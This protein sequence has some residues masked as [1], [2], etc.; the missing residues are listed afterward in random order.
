MLGDPGRV[1][2]GDGRVG[3]DVKVAK[4]LDTLSGRLRVPVDDPGA[5]APPDP[6]RG[7]PAGPQAG[8]T[9]RPPPASPATGGGP[10]A[11]VGR[12]HG[13][14]G[15][16]PRSDLETSTATDRELIADRPERARAWS[17]G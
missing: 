12:G 8:P 10:D 5:P 9:P 16:E 2:Q 6:P 11:G 7:R 1:P 15:A 14:L 3:L 13:R 4:A 17:P